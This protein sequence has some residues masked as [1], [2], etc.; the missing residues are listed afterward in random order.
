MKRARS[1]HQGETPRSIQR[2]TT[3]LPAAV[4]AAVTTA[5]AAAATTTAAAAAAAEAAAAAAA[6]TA[7]FL[8]LVHAKRTTVE[9]RAVGLGNRLLGLRIGAHGDEREA[10]RTAGL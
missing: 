2:T 3:D 9:H 10:A 5:T 1:A 6:A 8:G 7:T 4:T